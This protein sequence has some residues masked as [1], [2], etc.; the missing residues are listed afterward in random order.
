MYFIKFKCLL[1][2][3]CV[4]TVHFSSDMPYNEVTM[5]N[6]EDV[7]ELNCI[8]NNELQYEDSDIAWL[9]SN[10]PVLHKINCNM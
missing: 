1:I 10:Q 7:I 5:T 6:E 9:K 8:I 2:I 4:K 3:K